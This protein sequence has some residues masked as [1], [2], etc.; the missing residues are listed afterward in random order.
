MP[1]NKANIKEDEKAQT[2]DSLPAD[3]TA[4]GHVL[5][6][7]IEAAELNLC[8][9]P[10]KKL[11][12]FVVVQCGVH[13][14]LSHVCKKTADPRWDQKFAL[15]VQSMEDDLISLSVSFCISWFLCDAGFVII[16]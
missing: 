10:V 8:G 2:T 13:K 11:N 9:I 6:H 5:V 14:Q 7:V 1:Q 16:C 3:A 12:P 4:I 15:M